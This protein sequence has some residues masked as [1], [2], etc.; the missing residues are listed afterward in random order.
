[1]SGAEAR[2]S[3]LEH[4]LRLNAAM[5]ARQTDLAREAEIRQAKAERERDEA[6]GEVRAA[7]GPR[8]RFHAVRLSEGIPKSVGFF[9]TPE[10][11]AAF[12]DEL[13]VLR[14]HAQTQDRMDTSC[15]MRCEKLLAGER[16][17]REKA[18]K[19]RDEFASRR[20]LLLTG[21]GQTWGDLASSIRRWLEDYIPPHE[22]DNRATEENAV[23]LG[24]KLTEVAERFEAERDEEREKVKALR[25]ALK[26]PERC[27]ETCARKPCTIICC[28]D[29]PV[30]PF[31]YWQGVPL[32]VRVTRV[33]A[34]T[35]HREE[36]R[37]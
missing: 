37:C 20:N 29:H 24:A 9:T 19:E 7:L 23:W 36:T 8:V 31:L 18:E 12:E 6:R 26:E 22:Y 33:L 34:T 25:E 10:A 3:D 35:G 13:R 11:A 27:C 16:E 1:M 30:E 28:H 21:I 5:L 15:G 32:E 17:A 2:V 14:S 4:E